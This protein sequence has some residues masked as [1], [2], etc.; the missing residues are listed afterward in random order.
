MNVR[1]IIYIL[2]WILN[3]EGAFMLLPFI[4]SLLYGEQEGIAFLAC[5]GALY[6]NW[7]ADSF[8][9]AAEHGVF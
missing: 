8:K 4:V 6:F 9:K 1:A 5:C 3:M 7:N 2:G